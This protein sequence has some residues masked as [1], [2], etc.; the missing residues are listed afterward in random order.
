M[1]AR[2]LKDLLLAAPAGARAD[3]RARSGHA[4]RREGRRRSTRPARC[5]TRRP[6]IP[7]RRATTGTARRPNSPRSSRKHKV[8]LIAIGNGTASRETERLVA[9]MIAQLPG[10]EAAQGRR[11][12]GRRLGLFGLGAGGGGVSRP[13]RVAARR[14]VD[15]ATSAGSAR[16]TRQDRAEG[17]RRRA[18]SAR[19]RPART[20]PLA[21]RR[22]SRMR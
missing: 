19:R 22:W 9:D 5:S 11:Q 20:R 3:D 1:F 2:N 16:R 18:V 14:G 17:D 6:S 21:R 13:R 12:R 7:S 4:H 8:E 10:N 15:R